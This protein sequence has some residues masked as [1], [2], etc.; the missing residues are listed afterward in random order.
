MQTEEQA[1]AEQLA[2][3]EQEIADAFPLEMPDSFY[4]VD[5]DE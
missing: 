1:L 3:E 5:T 2:K 4:G